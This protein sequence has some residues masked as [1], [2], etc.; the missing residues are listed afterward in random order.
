MTPTD[1]VLTEQLRT[2]HP[3]ACEALL[4]RFQDKVM[5][6]AYGYT[7]NQSD[8]EDIFQD[9]FAEVIRSIGTFRGE[10]EL[11]TWIY[12]ITIRK[13]QEHHRRKQRKWM[14]SWFSDSE[15]ESADPADPDG[16]TPESLYIG[17]EDLENV[18]Q[19]VNRLPDLQRQAITLFYFNDL[20]YQEVAAVMETSVSS[21][22]SLLF[23]ARRNLKKTLERPNEEVSV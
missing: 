3:G 10:S 20:P 22:E 6:T 13:A 19:A 5:R 2:G 16:H 8:A 18:R 1:Q 23:R 14:F 9:T 7:G 21:V 17:H 4:R 12:R 15:D 11:G